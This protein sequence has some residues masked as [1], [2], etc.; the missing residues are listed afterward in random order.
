M[1]NSKKFGW[2]LRAIALSQI[3]ATSN[4]ELRSAA[5]KLRAQ[6]LRDT[7]RLLA[8]SYRADLSSGFEFWIRDTV[9]LSA[10]SYCADF[11]SGF[12]VATICDTAEEEEE[13]K[14]KTIF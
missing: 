1:V 11:S 7:I 8:L 5:R 2:Y 14:H 10:P 4:P 13:G 12:E 9:R 6:R 3:V